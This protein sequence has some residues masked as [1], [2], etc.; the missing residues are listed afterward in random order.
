MAGS[1]TWFDAA[2]GV[3]HMTRENGKRKL[4]CIK[5]NHGQTG[6]TV[7]L[8]ERFETNGRFKG[9]E[10]ATATTPSSADGGA[11]KVSGV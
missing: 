10:R 5:A 11:G 1:A 3:L 8:H 7:E 4:E 6:W 9:F 2:R